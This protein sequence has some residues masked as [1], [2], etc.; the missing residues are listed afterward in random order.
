M[1]TQEF[2]KVKAVGRGVASG[3]FDSDGDLDLCVVHH[4]S[5]AAI[6]R[7][8]STNSRLL[9]I[10]LIGV[11]SAREAINTLVKISV[12]GYEA[13][14]ELPGGTSY[15]ASHEHAL[16]FGLGQHQGDVSATI[17]WPSGMT[18]KVLIKA[19]QRRVLIV[20]NRGII[21]EIL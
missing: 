18:E 3:D 16:S 11:Q 1:E 13:Q 17:S 21:P 12:D 15:A 6:L 2:L 19:G 4:N 10:R 9:Q 5:P 8:E 20:E 7:N 14:Q